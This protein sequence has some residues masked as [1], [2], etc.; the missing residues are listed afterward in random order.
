MDCSKWP[1]SKALRGDNIFSKVL[2][3]LWMSWTSFRI[4]S[5]TFCAACSGGVGSNSVSLSCGCLMM[6]RQVN[7][8][9]IILISNVKSLKESPTYTS[10]SRKTEDITIHK[11]NRTF[12]DNLAIICDPISRYVLKSYFNVSVKYKE[13]VCTRHDTITPPVGA[14]TLSMIKCKLSWADWRRFG[15]NAWSLQWI[16]EI[17]GWL[18]TYVLIVEMRQGVELEGGMYPPLLGI[19]SNCSWTGKTQ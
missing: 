18:I 15:L 6:W 19:P 8:A 9:G 4:H 12:S 17:A 14:L 10:W 11:Y 1:C 5:I 13:V 7:S 3:I 2:S 16:F